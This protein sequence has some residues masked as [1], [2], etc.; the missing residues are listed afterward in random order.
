[1][2]KMTQNLRIST[3]ADQIFTYEKIAD[4]CSEEDNHFVTW[5]KKY[6]F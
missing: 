5:N 1:M 2:K 6:I 3:T 4:I